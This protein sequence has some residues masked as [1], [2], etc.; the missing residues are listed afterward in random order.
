MLSAEGA[1]PVPPAV[2]KVLNGAVDLHCHSG[3]SPFPRRLNHVEAAY[4]GARIGMR[5][6][7]VKSH[8]HN[9]VMD[10]LAMS[11]GSPT[12]PPPSTGGSRSTPRSAASTRRPW[13]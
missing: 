8:H 6:I 4:H 11:T 2:L 5:A 12:P 1:T 7:L 13:R 3:P 10:L 9:T